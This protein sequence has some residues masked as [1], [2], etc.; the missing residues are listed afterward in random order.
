MPNQCS[1]IT[2]IRQRRRNRHKLKSTRRRQ[3]TPRPYITLNIDISG[4]DEAF[5]QFKDTV[6]RLSETLAQ[7]ETQARI[8]EAWQSL[9]NISPR[10]LRGMISVQRAYSRIEFTVDEACLGNSSCKFNTRS[11]YMQC[12]VNPK[13]DCDDC[14]YFESYTC[15]S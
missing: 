12:A 7:P 15:S 5:R 2:T 6:T 14:R 10:V 1:L 8:S 9:M 4:L 11:P 13:G 3:I